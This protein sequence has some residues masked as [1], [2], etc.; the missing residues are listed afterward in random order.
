M[1]VNQIK[2]IYECADAVY[3]RRMDKQEAKTRL[4]SEFRNIKETT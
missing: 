3:K 4:Y 1:N 2:R